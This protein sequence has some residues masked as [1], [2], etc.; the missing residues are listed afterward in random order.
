M[1]EFFLFIYFFKH[2]KLE[3]PKCKCRTLNHVMMGRE[4]ANAALQDWTTGHLLVT[5]QSIN[6]L[7]GIFKTDSAIWVVATLLLICA[8]VTLLMHTHA[9]TCTPAHTGTQK[10]KSGHLQK[11][12]HQHSVSCC[13][14]V[15]SASAVIEV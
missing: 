2:F 11:L 5:C 9:H 6:N 1:K 3:V 13:Y 14:S 7:A 15:K 10:G 4:H 12:T 8:C